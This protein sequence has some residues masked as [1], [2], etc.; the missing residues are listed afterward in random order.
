MMRC[1]TCRGTGGVDVVGGAEDEIIED[2][3][4]DC[5]GEGTL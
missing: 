3:C 2:S 5:D 1:D 4:P